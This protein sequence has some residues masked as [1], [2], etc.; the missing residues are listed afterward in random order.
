VRSLICACVVLALVPAAAAAQVQLV[1]NRAGQPSQLRV[2]VDPSALGI[3]SEVPRSAVLAVAHGFR[4]DRR[5]RSAPC[6]LVQASAFDC[7]ESSRIGRGS[8]VVVVSGAIV[9]GG[10]ME[11][12]ATIDV[13]MAPPFARGDFFGVEVQVSEPRFGQRGRFQGRLLP[14]N[15]PRFG[16]ELRFDSFAAVPVPPGVTVD[17]RRLQLTVGARR[18]VVRRRVVRRRVRRG[19]RVVVRRRVVRRRIRYHLIRNPRSCPGSWPYELRLGFSSGDRTIPG[20]VTC[21]R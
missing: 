17:L 3:P 2:D 8:A 4:F 10:S 20:A 6:S 13:F 19:G 12:T 15:D 14:V 9:P 21:T 16:A 1:P 11:L 5:A 18:T 7:P